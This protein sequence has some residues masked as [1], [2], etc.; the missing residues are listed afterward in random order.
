MRIL[1]STATTEVAKRLG[2][3]E[4][5][6]Q[7]ADK[8]DEA[9]KLAGIRIHGSRYGT[10]KAPQESFSIYFQNKKLTEVLHTELARYSLFEP[11]Q[12]KWVEIEFARALTLPQEFWITLEFRAGRTKGV[13]VSYD[14]STGGK[15]SRVGLPGMKAKDVDVGGDWIVEPVLVNCISISRI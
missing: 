10:P 12:E 4:L 7:Y 1:Y 3:R 6:Q 14:T 15:F 13:Y 5:L 11:G 2:L 8:P 9:S